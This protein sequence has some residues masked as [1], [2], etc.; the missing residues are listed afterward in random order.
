MGNKY[1]FICILLFLSLAGS[2]RATVSIFGQSAA[3][4]VSL[5]GGLVLG[6]A[7]AN[8]TVDALCFFTG[9]QR[10]ESS[11]ERPRQQASVKSTVIKLG[12]SVI[13]SVL[14]ASAGVATAVGLLPEVAHGDSPYVPAEV[15]GPSAA[16]GSATYTVVNA[17]QQA[18]INKAYKCCY[19]ESG[20]HEQLTEAEADVESGQNDV[21]K[22]YGTTGNESKF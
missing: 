2:V 19:G 5:G 11:T 7:A 12:K 9:S 1:F 18:V 14:G 17:F 3:G 16:A 20:E 15:F 21:T 22:G 6:R 10:Q 8:A 4:A 13:P